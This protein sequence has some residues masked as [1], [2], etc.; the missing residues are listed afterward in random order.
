MWPMVMRKAGWRWC[1]L[2]FI[3]TPLPELSSLVIDDVIDQGRVVRALA[4]TQVLPVTCPMCGQPTERVHAYH[5]RQIAALP[6]AR[7]AVAPI[8]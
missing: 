2:A 7:R 8:G 6:M 3:R 4:L 5:R 1:D